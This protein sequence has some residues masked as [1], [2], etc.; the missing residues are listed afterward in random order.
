MRRP[1]IGITCNSVPVEGNVMQGMIRNVLNNDYIA[2]VELAGG[3]PLLLPLTGDDEAVLAQVA[4]VDGVLLSGG[5]DID[6]RLFGEEPLAQL[7]LVN[8]ERDRHELLV[9]KAAAELAK[10]IFGICR[11][12]QILNVACGGTLHQEVAL[13]DGCNLRHFQTTAQRDALWHSVDIVPGSLLA[14]MVG[15]GR[16]PVNSFHHQAVK[17]VAPGFVSA[18]AS[19][20]GLIEAIEQPGDRLVFGVQWHPELLAAS[21]PAMLALFQALVASAAKARD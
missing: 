12:V 21:M 2:S 9:V 6:P 10:P 17:A 19:P 3:A 1:L 14:G 15:S 13:V 8:H 16:Q 7:G 18:A 4:A 5:P 11:G 20:D